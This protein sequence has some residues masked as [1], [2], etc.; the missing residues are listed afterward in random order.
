MKKFLCAVLALSVLFC[1][2]CTALEND[3]E[4]KSEESGTKL[5]ESEESGDSSLPCDFSSDSHVI[6]SDTESTDTESFPEPLT[7]DVSEFS[8]AD[9][10][11]ADSSESMEPVSE[12]SS[13]EAGYSDTAAITAEIA[14]LRNSGFQTNIPESSVLSELKAYLEGTGYGYF[15]CDLEYNAYAAYGCDRIFKT[16]S[17]AKLPYIKYLC[18]LADSGDIDLDG[19]MVFEE[20]HKTVGSGIMKNMASGASFSIRT[21]IDYTL[22]Y[23]DN[24]AYSMLLERFGLKAYLESLRA[25]GVNYSTVNGYADC[26]ASEMAALLFDTARYNGKNSSLILDAGCNAS[27]NYQ[28][29]AEL[30]EYKVLQKYGAIKPGNVAYH[31]IAVVYAP[32]P[33]ILVIYTTIDYES[34]A[35]NIP[36]RKIARL[37]DNLNKAL[38]ED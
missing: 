12:D 13:C 18:T 1:S 28:I 2:A 21:L 35:K 14:A 9:S 23:S 31:D 6:S 34:A 25:L 30:R 8:G 3:I 36:F 33:Y 19:T 7:S 15:Y 16:A 38:Y 11:S 17:T 20:R 24:I 29:G 27:Y 5:P 37:T 32:H 22:R 26:T 10:E 4:N